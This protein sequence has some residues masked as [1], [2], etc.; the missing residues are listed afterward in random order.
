[1]GLGEE[2]EEDG[3]GDDGEGVLGYVGMW[4]GVGWVMFRGGEVGFVVDL[5]GVCGIFYV[6]GG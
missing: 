5:W 2:S 3:E 1:M 6:I 4:G